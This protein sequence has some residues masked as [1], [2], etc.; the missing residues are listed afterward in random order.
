MVSSIAW[1]PRTRFH[2]YKKPNLRALYLVLLPTCIGTEM[3]SGFDSSMLNGLQT[4]DSWDTFYH[5][6]RLTILR[7]MLA[8]YSSSAI[9]NC[10]AVPYVNDNFAIFIISRLIF[11]L[12]IPFAVVAASSPIGELSYPKERAHLGSLFNSSYVVGSILAVGVT[13]G[14]CN[15]SSNWG[16]L[17]P[18]LLQLTPSLLQV[19]FIYFLP[20]SPRWLI[21]KG[22]GAKAMSI[23]VKYHAEGDIN[24]QFVKAECAQIE[25]T[26]EIELETR[27]TS[28]KDFVSTAGMRKH[29]LIAAFLGLFTQW[30]GNGLT[31][32]LLPPTLDQIGFHANRYKN[33]VNLALTCWSF[34]NTTAPALVATKFRRRTVFLTPSI[35]MFLI[36]SGWTAASAQY[37]QT[38]SKPASKA[39]IACGI[40][41]HSPAYNLGYCSLIYP[42]L[43]ELFPFYTCATEI[44]FHHF[45]SRS[46]SSAS[47]FVD[48]TGPESDFVNYMVW[49][50]FEV[51]SVYF[52]FPKTAHH[53][54]EELAFYQVKRVNQETQHEVKHDGS[55]DETA[56]RIVSQ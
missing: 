43:V 7:V 6:P 32:Y 26:L 11:G 30:S 47:Q 3:T 51:I 15:M 39:V 40:F 48:P 1:P 9:I 28:W 29:L 21:S 44:A 31:G 14:T 50:A 24:S 36:F 22:R 4:V 42:Y 53:T 5:S 54:L 20:E 49:L 35:S 12:R 46:A 10:P 27:K 38:G 2:G 52:V 41:I 19:A 25:R 45:F 18:S 17:I 37:A 16:W 8:T 23:L 56:G 34:V 55:L 33:L 13:M